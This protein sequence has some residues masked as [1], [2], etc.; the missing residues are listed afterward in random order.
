[1]TQ[2]SG[3]HQA[4]ETLHKSKASAKARQVGYGGGGVR[5]RGM[6]IRLREEHWGK[7]EI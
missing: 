3:G 1:M 6:R 2:E 7:P 5:G 4:V